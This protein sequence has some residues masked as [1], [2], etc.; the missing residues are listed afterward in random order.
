MSK[1]SIID[2][3]KYIINEFNKANIDSYECNYLLAEFFD[4][5]INDLILIKSVDSR[6]FK[7]IQHIVKMRIKG[8]PLTKIFK[9][10]YFYGLQFYINNNVLS[11]RPETEILIDEVLKNCV[12]KDIKILDLCAGSGCIGITLKSLGFSDVTC[13]D[14]SKKACKV[15]KKN[16]KRLSQYVKIIRSNLF[17]KLDDK[18]DVI[19]SNPPYIKSSEIDKLDKEVKNYDPIISLDGGN[20]GLC[21][22]KTIISNADKYLTENGKIFFEIGYDQ[23]ESVCKILNEYNYDSKVIK[24]YSN[25]D[26]VVLATRR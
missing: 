3:K 24:D 17:D 12:N 21:F 5:S 6:Q 25:N 22:Y 15:I 16:S 19:V 20:D 10:A 4:C 1:Y 26:R 11:C 13:L 2:V 8:K 23:A 18:Y 14:V 7:K 9:R